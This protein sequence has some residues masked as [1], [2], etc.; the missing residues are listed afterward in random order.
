MPVL[1]V[2]E[3]VSCPQTKEEQSVRQCLLCGHYDGYSSISIQLFVRCEYGEADK[4]KKTLE[5]NL[6]EI[7]R[8]HAELAKEVIELDEGQSDE[9][10]S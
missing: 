10:H 9:D 7:H 3:Y 4:P 2:L 1:K 5:E 8:E 6:A